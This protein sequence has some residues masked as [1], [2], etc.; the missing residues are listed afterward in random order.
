MYSVRSCMQGSNRNGMT[1]LPRTYRHMKHGGVDVLLRRCVIALMRSEILE[2]IG[3][4]EVAHGGPV[5]EHL[6][7]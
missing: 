2:F 5:G 6:D 4:D 7:T 1:V 3:A